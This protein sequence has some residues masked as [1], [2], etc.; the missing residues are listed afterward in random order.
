MRRRRGRVRADG[1]IDPDAVSPRGRG[2]AEAHEE[3]ERREMRAYA[4]TDG[5]RRA[6]ILS[7]FGEP[8]EGPCGRC[9]NDRRPG[10][11]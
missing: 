7:H 1:P 4:E 6:F 8:F 2:A 9:D 3:G 11:R 5:C 10:A